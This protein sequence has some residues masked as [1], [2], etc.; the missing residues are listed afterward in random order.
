M[1]GVNL[2]PGQRVQLRRGTARLRAWMVVGPTCLSLLAVAYVVNVLAWD[3]DVGS[4]TAALE[5]TKAKS[6]EADVKIARLKKELKEQQATVRANKSVGEQPDWASLL[7]LLAS[8]LGKDAAL[9]SCKVE[10]VLPEQAERGTKEQA[11]L[12]GR[13]QRL[14]LTLKGLSR[15]QEAASQFVIQLEQTKVF[16]KVT[17]LETKRDQAN[18]DDVVFDVMCDISDSGA[19]S[20]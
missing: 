14:K 7:T 15:T 1:N 2:I 19:I 8:T 6:K 11:K 13:P 17:L 20:K 5:A 18:K 4:A 9:I 12:Q 10:P 3:T 16:E